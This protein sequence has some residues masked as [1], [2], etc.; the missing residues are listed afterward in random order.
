MTQIQNEVISFS[1]WILLGYNVYPYLIDLKFKH[2]IQE[3]KNYFVYEN[4][5]P[6]NLSSFFCVKPKLNNPRL[7]S[8]SG[9]FLLFGFA[10]K[11]SKKDIPPEQHLKIRM[12]IKK[13]IPR[14]IIKKE[15]KI[16][17]YEELK[18]LGVHRAFLFPEIDNVSQIV[19]SNYK[20]KK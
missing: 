2:L 14:I 16:E 5:D 8:Q 3:E 4:I 20:F 13:E 17:I 15:N 18:Q 12:K 10:N 6:L 19:A 7:I 1:Q 9:A 11:N